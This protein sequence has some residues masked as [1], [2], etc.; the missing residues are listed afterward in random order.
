MQ[1]YIF[2]CHPVAAKTWCTVSKSSALVLAL[3]TLALATSSSRVVE[4]IYSTVQTG[5][6]LL[7]CGHLQFIRMLIF[8]FLV[9]SSV[10]S[11]AVDF[12]LLIKSLQ[13]YEHF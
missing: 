6:Y 4:K 12:M 10:Q 8:N 9:C 5:Y 3:V 11:C 13:E 7:C 1:R 2:V